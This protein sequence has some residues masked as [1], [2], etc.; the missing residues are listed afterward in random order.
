MESS[1]RD[2][3]VH[4]LLR[5]HPDGLTTAG[6]RRAG[7]TEEDIKSLVS[8]G[9]LHHLRRGVYL[10]RQAWVGLLPWDRHLARACAIA[11]TLPSLG[12]D[13]GGLVFSHHSGLAV[14]ELALYGVDDEVHASRVEHGRC[15][16]GGG[17]WVHGPVP[18]TE[19]RLVNGLPVVSPAL[20]CLQ[21]AVLSG[22]ESGLVAAD[23]ALRLRRCTREDLSALTDLPTL[24]AARPAARVVAEL[25]HGARESAGESRT[26]WLLHLIGIEVEHQVEIRDARGSFV[27][28]SDFRVK[29]S[30]VLLEFDGR[31]KYATH[32]DLMAEKVRED[33]LRELG[34][35]VVRITWADLD[36]PEAVRAKILAALARSK[37][38]ASA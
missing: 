9:T 10:D 11:P 22:P 7:L 29:N 35:E 18:V 37:V 15:R 8:A 36:R 31:V 1:V 17:L 13:P 19:V 24:R 27:G 23:S 3:L 12:C 34:Y 4:Q 28:R 26:A 16:H 21:V 6:L 20:A 32:A 30:R 14:Q 38:R 33:R 5:A 2:E 25:A